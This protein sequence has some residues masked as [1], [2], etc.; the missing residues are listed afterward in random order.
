[1]NPAPERDISK[2]QLGIQE[3]ILSFEELHLDDTNWHKKKEEKLLL[4]K[5]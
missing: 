4:V 2:V 3:K 5:F 1:M